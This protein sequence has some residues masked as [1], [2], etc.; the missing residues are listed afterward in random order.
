[1]SSPFLKLQMNESQEEQREWFETS[2][3]TKIDPTAGN[4]SG[5]ERSFTVASKLPQPTANMRSPI[6]LFE[7]FGGTRNDPRAS[8]L[9]AG[10][11]RAQPTAWLGSGS[12]AS[13]G[14]AVT[15]NSQ[16]NMMIVSTSE[17]TNGVKRRRIENSMPK[18]PFLV[19]PEGAPPVPSKDSSESNAFA[20][21]RGTEGP[22]QA[23]AIEDF[24][25]GEGYVVGAAY[26]GPEFQPPGHS[27]P[28]EEPPI[29]AMENISLL[30]LLQTRKPVRAALS[31]LTGQIQK[32]AVEYCVVNRLNCSEEQALQ[33]AI[34]VALRTSPVA[35]AFRQISASLSAVEV[36]L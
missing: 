1:M 5:A 12:E 16:T 29:F 21:E 9:P 19:D 20:M 7:L 26:S 24:Q 6:L 32:T 36:T 23:K 31:T 18:L 4:S 34:S 17:R 22:R 8:Q 33:T 3:S 10:F 13:L 2:G 28:F 14:A 27:L 15:N 35:S 30:P 11:L 25:T